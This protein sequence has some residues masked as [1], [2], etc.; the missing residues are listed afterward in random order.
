MLLRPE[1]EDLAAFACSGDGICDRRLR[2]VD[3]QLSPAL[4]LSCSTG[5]L[6]GHD[7]REDEV[8]GSDGGHIFVS[9][10]HSYMVC[11]SH[12]ASWADLL[13]CPD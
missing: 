6:P 1:F 12:A 10:N 11:L 5:S 2:H 9:Y 3:D 4:V 13:C 8:D 7:Q